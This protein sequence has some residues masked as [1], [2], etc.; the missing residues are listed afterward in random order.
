ME[1]AHR[2]C[3]KCISRYCK[4]P[5]CPMAN[6]VHGC[7]AI[8]HQCKASDHEEVCFQKRVPCINTVYGCEAMMPRDMIKV[9]LAHCPASL[10]H[11]KFIWERVDRNLTKSQD[12]ISD[13]TESDKAERNYVEEFLASDV[14]RIKN[15][16]DLKEKDKELSAMLE[17]S[18]A[19]HLLVGAPHHRSFLYSRGRTNLVVKRLSPL[20]CCFYMTTESS[21]REQLHILIRC[22]EIV[23]R[24]EFEDHYMVQHNIIHSGL[25]GWLVHH[26]P[27]NEYGCNFSIPRLLPSPKYFKLMYNKCSRVFAAGLK[28]EYLPVRSEDTELV[29]GWYMTRLAQQRELAAYGYDDIPTDPLS[30]LPVEVFRV[31]ITF[32]D[33]SAL[34][35]LSLTCQK[36]RELCGSLIKGNMVQLAWKHHGECWRDISKV[37]CVSIQACAWGTF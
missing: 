32:L 11:C 24:D 12:H 15:N 6:C 2:H 34:F 3:A 23:R 30:H 18:A 9:H 35:C 14:E 36:L 10:V 25:Y 27:L 17:P 5:E 29:D 37:I 8:M 1:E 21:H 19:H 4:I 16:L 22:N 20:V 13:N 7:G 28:D 26:C 33:S 31:I